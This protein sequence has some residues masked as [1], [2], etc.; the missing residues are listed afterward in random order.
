MPDD[1]I[2]S[3]YKSYI[4]GLPQQ[5]LDK[6]KADREDVD[7]YASETPSGRDENW[8]FWRNRKVKDDPLVTGYNYLFITAPELPIHSKSPSMTGGN[9]TELILSNNQR[10]LGLPSEGGDNR[11]SIYSREIIEALSGSTMS[12]IP[13][14]SN[15]AASYMTSDEALATVDYSETWNRYK[16]VLGTTAKDSRISGQMTVNYL[17]DGHLTIMKLHRLWLEYIEK[18]FMGDTLTGRYLAGADML[19]H[20]SRTIDYMCSIYVFTVQPDG[21]TITHWCR[22]TGCF[23]TKV[24]W[25]ELTSEDGGIDIKKTI[26]VEYQFS[27]KEDMNLYILRDFNLLST[28]DA[29]SSPTGSYYTGSSVDSLRG[30]SSGKYPGVVYGGKDLYTGMPIFKLVLPNPEQS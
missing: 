19:N 6:T 2:S 5:S 14:L 18:A 15:R 12:M 23:P 11:I 7:Y 3:E 29:L 10:V 4:L 16:I 21:E 13:V 17:E 27:Y 9:N 28:G 8:T 24:P 30:A 1:S 26:P 22:Y 20:L 25:G